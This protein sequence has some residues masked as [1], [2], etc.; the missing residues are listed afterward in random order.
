MDEV[1]QDVD[2][3]ELDLPL[4][5]EPGTAAPEIEINYEIERAKEERG[6]REPEDMPGFGQG[7]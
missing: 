4:S 7:A 6:N 2:G 1:P 3:E 5:Q